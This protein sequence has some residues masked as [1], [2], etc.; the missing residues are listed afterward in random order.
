[1]LETDLLTGEVNT[2]GTITHEM[3]WHLVL[4]ARDS[5]NDYVAVFEALLQPPTLH[6]ANLMLLLLES[7][8]SAELLDVFDVD[9][10][11]FCAVIGK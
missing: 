8:A 2:Y 7:G 5:T 10:V 6:I 4:S 9:T 11:D 1:M 3:C